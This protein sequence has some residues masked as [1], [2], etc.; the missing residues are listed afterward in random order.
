MVAF[1]SAQEAASEPL[2]LTLVLPYLLRAI[3]LNFSGLYIFGGL[4]NDSSRR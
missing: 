1:S 4:D 2:S 3:H